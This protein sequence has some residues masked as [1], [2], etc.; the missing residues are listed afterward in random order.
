MPQRVRQTSAC[1]WINGKT[2][3]VARSVR[4]YVPKAAAPSQANAA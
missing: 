3:G 4:P 1:L 2:S